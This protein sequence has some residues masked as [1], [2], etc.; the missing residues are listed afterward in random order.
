MPQ[1]SSRKRLVSIEYSIDHDVIRVR[2]A[3]GFYHRV[4]STLGQE[5]QLPTRRQNN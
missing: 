5:K 3:H 4:E 2:V 1:E